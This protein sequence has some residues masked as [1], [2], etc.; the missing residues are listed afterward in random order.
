MTTTPTNQAREDAKQLRYHAASLTYNDTNAE[1]EAKHRLHEIAMRI[2]TGFY[3]STAPAGM[4]TVP[5]WRDI[6]TAPE[7]VSVLL[8]CNAN[9]PIYCGRKRTGQFYEPQQRVL[10]WRC[11]SSGTFAHPIK[12]TPLPPAPAGVV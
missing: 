6:A 3:T 9:I 11:D 10:A 2:E 5:Q 12:W 8:Y 1:G 7:G 4:V